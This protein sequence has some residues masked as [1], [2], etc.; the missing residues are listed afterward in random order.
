MKL[1]VCNNRLV[2]FAAGLIALGL[3]HAAVAEVPAR[4]GVQGSISTAAGGPIADGDYTA[5]FALYASANAKQALWTEAAKLKVAQGRFA[6]S[7]GANKPIPAWLLTKGDATWLGVQI[8]AEPETARSPIQLAPFALRASSA[9]GLTCTGCLSVNGLKADGDLNLAGHAIKS[10][11]LVAGSMQAGAVT[12]Q[13]FTGDGSK[14]TGVGVSPS[15]CAK[16]KLVN[17][18][19]KSGKVLCINAGDAGGDPLEAVSG[20][21]LTT[22]FAKPIESKTV[23]KGIDDNNPIGTVDEITVPDVGTVKKFSVSVKLTNSNV[24]DL[25]VV[26][27]PPDNSKIVLHK[28]GPAAKSLDEAYPV[29]KKPASGNIDAWIGKNPKGKWRLRIIDDK[30][31]NNGKDGQ[32]TA[33]SIN[34]LTQGGTQV[35]GKGTLYAA[36]GFGHQKSAGPPGPCNED[37]YGRMYFDTKDKRLYY[38]DGDWRKILPE[39]LCG[40]GVI[41]P[42]EACDDSNVKD[43]DG[44]TAQCKKNICGDGI[45]WVGKEECDDGNVQSGDGCSAACKNEMHQQCKSYTVLKE[46]NRNVNYQGSVTCDSGFKNIWYRFLPPAGVK[47]PT[48][49]PPKQKCGTHAP[50]W[51][52]GSHPAVKDGIV[53]RKVCFHWSNSTCHWNA[54]IGVINCATYYIYRLPKTPVCN[55]R[56]CAM[57]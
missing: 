16:G 18:I 35:T 45:I 43:G 25:E 3:S 32:L 42:G 6:W 8:A 57:N 4:L 5:K 13:S 37:S 55:L 44:C 14:L 50:G 38:C 53:S 9:A 1:T 49:S 20:G 34:V 51:M 21:L 28:G 40:N 27:Y 10:T 12:A 26:L 33:W 30:F 19:D 46:S 39:P 23:P 15:S 41:N 17:G 2:A 54:T 56:Y 22:Q 31:L 47:M 48:S 24:G 36:G 7:L 11:V 29:T 52:Q